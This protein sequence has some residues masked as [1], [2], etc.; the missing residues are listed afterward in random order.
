MSRKKLA[1]TVDFFDYEAAEADIDAELAAGF[2]SGVLEATNNQSKMGLELTKLI[3]ENSNKGKNFTEDEI[4]SIFNR[5]TK[6]VLDNHNLNALLDK[7]GM[8]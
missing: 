3:V 7:L 4:Y 1:K 5:A 8:K 2:M 6:V